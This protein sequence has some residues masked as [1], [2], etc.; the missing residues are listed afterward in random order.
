MEWDVLQIMDGGLL[1]NYSFLTT[2]WDKKRG[3]V[4]N[5]AHDSLY[6]PNP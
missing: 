4:E 2:D 1:G 3:A 5:S 6:T